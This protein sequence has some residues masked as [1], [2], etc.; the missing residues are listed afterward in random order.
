MNNIKDLQVKHA[1][2]SIDSI[3]NA[4]PVLFKCLKKLNDDQKCKYI[5]TE[6]A[7]YNGLE[8]KYMLKLTAKEGYRNRID[9]LKE[10]ESSTGKAFLKY[11]EITEEEAVKS[12]VIEVLNN[13]RNQIKDLLA[14]IQEA[15]K[16]MSETL[17]NLE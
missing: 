7:Q 1:N 11:V 12:M 3:E 6:F 9:I 14:S 16:N 8:K 4:F 15:H 5:G 10:V 2:E 17:N 13:Q